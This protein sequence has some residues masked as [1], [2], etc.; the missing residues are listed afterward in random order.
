MMYPKAEEYYRKAV[1][2]NP[3]VSIFLFSG[4]ILFRRVICHRHEVNI[5][6]MKSVFLDIYSINS[7]TQNSLSLDIDV[8]TAE[9]YGAR[10]PPP[11]F[12]AE[13]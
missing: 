1:Q 6:S 8:G 5:S 13:Y 11:S 12:F 10:T 3:E 4:F 9:H 7:T 2:L